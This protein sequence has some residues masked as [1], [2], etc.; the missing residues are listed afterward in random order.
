MAD[1]LRLLK[2]SP[3][4]YKQELLS[5]ID[6]LWIYSNTL[7]ILLTGKT[8]MGKSSLINALLGTNLIDIK[9]NSLQADTKNVTCYDITKNGIKIRVCDSPGLQDRS[10]REE[11]YIADMKSKIPNPDIVLYCMRMDETRIYTDDTNAMLKFNKAFNETEFWDR[12]FFVLTFA[13]KIEPP[14]NQQ[15]MAKEYFSKKLDAWVT[16]LHTVLTDQLNI[17]LDTDAHRKRV[18]PAGYED[19]HLPDREY[20]LSSLWLNIFEEANKRAQGGILKS[21]LKRIITLDQAADYDFSKSELHE[22]PIIIGKNDTWMQDLM[23]FVW[24]N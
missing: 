21:S 18:I 14:K 24:P 5:L 9:E 13:N 8:G 23:K 19:P 2:Y 6:Q 22:Q 16:N 15:D 7:H 12:T 4:E 17:T 20:W 11:E 3:E 10:E 1:M